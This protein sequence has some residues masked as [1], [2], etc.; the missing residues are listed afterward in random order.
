MN[1]KITLL[2]LAASLASPTFA[3]QGYDR[4]PA[5][6]QEELLSEV[7]ALPVAGE[8]NLRSHDVDIVINNG[9][10]TTT[11]TQVL[12][13]PTDR[14]LEAT[15]SFPLPDE[16][17]L[18]ELTM[19]IDGTPAIGEVVEKSEAER[20]YEEES[21]AGESAAVASQNGFSDYR[22]S[23]NRVPA[24]GEVKVRVAYYQPLDID[25]G[26]GRYLYPLQGGNTADAAMNSSF[27]SMEKSVSD[28]MTIDV[29]VKT[30]FPI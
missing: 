10:A 20:I 17:A 9:F 27:W 29:T 24:R 25:Q 13:N 7:P 18:S 23:V 4:L 3:S 6:Q 19:W 11:I 15:W 12:D 21:K 1:H 22:L 28:P 2:A 26:V 8:L 30:A 14:V 5:S 16:A